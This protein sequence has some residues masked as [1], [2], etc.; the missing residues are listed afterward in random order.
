MWRALGPVIGKKKEASEPPNITQDA[1]NNF[2]VNIGPS[3]S[4]GV[5]PSTW[6]VYTRLPVSLPAR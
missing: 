1:L 3:T 4:S 5:P 2:Y 6:P